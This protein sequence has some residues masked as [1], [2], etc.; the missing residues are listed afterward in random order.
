MS[1]AAGPGALICTALAA[2]GMSAED[3]ARSTRLRVGL[4]EQMAEDDFASTGGDVYAR[5]HLRAIAAVL[6]I[7][8]DELLAS[9]DALSASQRP[10]AP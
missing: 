10:P 1:Y 4:I 8:A 3:L 2:S 5:G 6:G 9:Y 7:D